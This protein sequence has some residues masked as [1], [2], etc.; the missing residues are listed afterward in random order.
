MSRTVKETGKASSTKILRFSKILL[1]LVAAVVA[2]RPDV[3]Y[4]ALS[5]TGFSFYKDLLTVA[6]LRAFRLKRV[7]HL[8]NK[9]ISRVN[10]RMNRWMY[11]FVFDKA[12]VILLSGKLYK[13]IEAFVPETMVYTCPNGITDTT[14]AIGA[15][16]N[17]EPVKILF[18]S[19]LME[20]KGVVVLLEA[21]SIL[22]AKGLDFECDFVGA[23]GDLSAIQFEEIK[24]RLNL[25][26]KIKYI[27]K[28]YDQE[29]L[30]IFR[31][32]DLFIHPTL[33]DCFPLVLLEAMQHSLP[34]VSTFEGG[35][36]DIVEDGVTGYLV[37]PGDAGILAGKMEILIRN[38]GLR[39]Q[40]GKAGR[41]KY[42]NEFRLE[43]FEKRLEEILGQVAG[44]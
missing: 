7:Y 29:K 3:C 26:D 16:K 41:K 17:G 15:R 2:N 6:L 1:E 36:P 43:I 30:D 40:M 13:D 35:I 18:L 27:G 20:S 32:S 31:N 5:T 9:G 28:R 22:S 10:N 8:H 25:D 19:N 11:K 21:C 24:R 38:H 39:E 34:V 42:Q 23:E 14:P 12:A 33:S 44:M 37:P 4:L